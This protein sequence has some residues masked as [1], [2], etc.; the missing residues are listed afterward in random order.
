MQSC[1]ETFLEAATAY[2]AKIAQGHPCTDFAQSLHVLMSTHMFCT[3]VLGMS[4]LLRAQ[5]L[6]NLLRRAACSQTRPLYRQNAIDTDMQAKRNT[7]ISKLITFRTTKAKTKVNFGVNCLCEH[8]CETSSVPINVNTKAKAT[9]Y[10]GG[11]NF[12][13]VCVATVCL[14]RK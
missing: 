7:I 4:G 5:V 8:D 11:L 1:A 3:N 12:T 9:K 2:L 10:L 13:L 6:H 14:E